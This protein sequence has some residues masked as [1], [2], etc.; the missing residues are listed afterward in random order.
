[1]SLL[2]DD[3]LW[4]LVPNADNLNEAR[5]VEVA[6][7]AKL[8]GMELPKPV[9]LMLPMTNTKELIELERWGRSANLC[10]RLLDQMDD[11]Y[12]TPW[13]IATEA[14]TALQSKVESLS[15]EVERLRAQLAKLK[16]D[17][18][19]V[20]RWAVHH[21]TKP[22]MTAKEALSCI[23]HYPA[24]KAITKSYV[25]G[26]LPETCDPFAERDQLRAQL[27]AQGEAVKT[28]IATL[29]RDGDEWGIGGNLRTALQA[30]PAQPAQG[31]TDG[32]Q[33]RESER[34]AFEADA[35]PLGFDLLRT[36]N[37]NVEPWDDYLEM[38]TGMRWGG[39]LARAAI[40]K[41]QQS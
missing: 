28:A 38:E 26:K 2:T 16:D 41:G 21:G 37:P 6:L 10:L 20:E 32:E 1:M 30:A 11:G 27:E 8:A 12:W 34:P 5:A 17:L 35:A 29:E 39:W 24:I 33:D 25:D 22:H 15:A 13:H 36:A 14:V 9:M 19:F 31:L 40:Q 4:A 7:L 23:Q 3:E 18:A